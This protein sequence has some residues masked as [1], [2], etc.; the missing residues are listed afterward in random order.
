MGELDGLVGLVQVKALVKEIQAF[1][2]IQERRQV[3]GLRCEPV[4]LHMVMKGNPGTGKTT[5]ARI[6]GRIY[7]AM[8]VLPRGHL[9]EAERADLVGEYVG[10]TAQ[11]TRELIKKALGGILFVDEAYALA[12]GGERDFGKEAIDTLVKAI[13]DHKCEM[14]VIL[15]GYPVEMDYFMQSNPGLDSR[16]PLQMEFPDY[17]GEELLAIAELLCQERQYCLS[18]AA[19]LALR[20]HLGRPGGPEA[21]GLPGNARQV[22]NLVERALRRQ[23][24]R[25]LGQAAISHEDLITLQP[26]DL[27]EEVARLCAIA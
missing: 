6:L 5:V 9:V 27:G 19:R 2:E 25:L 24:I 14:V 16:F 23:A 4:V 10:H 26:A 8:G 13:E 21:G 17:T 15:A 3:A 1:M 20:R 18:P 7:R 11:R 22:R 12:R